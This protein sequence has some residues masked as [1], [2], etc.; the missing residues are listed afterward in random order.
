[1]K[2]KIKFLACLLVISVIII[3]GCTSG[4]NIAIEKASGGPVKLANNYYRFDSQEFQKAVQEKRAI[5]L[6]FKANWCSTC[7]E[8][9]KIIHKVFNEMEGSDFIGF[10]IHYNDEE[11]QEFDNQI[12]RDYQVAYQN[13]A[14]FLNN[15]GKESSRMLANILEDRIK[16]AIEKAKNSN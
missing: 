6:Y 3:S 14:I 7:A 10:E 15:E 9:V 16:S 4:K 13:T 11:S 5:L 8:T 2:N 1:M 12:I